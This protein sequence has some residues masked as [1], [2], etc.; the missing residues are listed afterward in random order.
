MTIAA[1]H[2]I[3]DFFTGTVVP[4]LRKHLGDSIA[5]GVSKLI[6]FADK[7]LAPAHAQLKKYYHHFKQRIIDI[8]STFVRDPQDKSRVKVR[9]TSYLL[10]DPAA[11]NVTMTTTEQ[12]LDW[13][14][15]PEEIRE[16]W[17]RTNSRYYRMDMKETAD[18][19]IR[20]R[21]AE[22]SMDLNYE[23]A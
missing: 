12:D 21:A 14:Q 18:D 10:S 17:I 19:Q 5:E 4:T 9:T 13:S 3:R 16:N 1:W 7:K 6:E 11:Q 15:V 8:K 20:K 22:L 2:Y 23:A